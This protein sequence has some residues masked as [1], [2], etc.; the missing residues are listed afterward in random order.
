MFSLRAV[1][2]IVIHRHF[3]SATN[4][5]FLKVVKDYG[6]HY[7]IGK[8]GLESEKE[9]LPGRAGGRWLNG[10]DGVLVSLWSGL[11]MRVRA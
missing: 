3:K 10:I 5:D 4:S 1:I 11:P 8:W 7:K 2:L 9:G 6:F